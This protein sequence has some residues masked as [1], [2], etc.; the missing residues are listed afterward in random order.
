MLHREPRHRFNKFFTE[1][2]VSLQIAKRHFR[3]DH[4]K[5]SRMPRGIGV[6]RS[7][8]RTEGVDVRPLTVR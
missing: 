3:F 5:L 1:I 8:G 6:F 7:E 4:P 2:H